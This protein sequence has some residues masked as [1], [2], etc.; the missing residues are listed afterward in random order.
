MPFYEHVFVA[1][2]DVT[3]A[4]VDQIADQIGGVVEEAGGK[5]ALR[6]Y[7]GLRNLAYRIRKNRKGHFI[8][9]RMDAPADAVTEFERQLRLNEDVIRILT[10]RQDELD[11]TPSIIMQNKQS[12]DGRGDRGDRGRRDRDDRDDRPPREDRAPRAEAAAEGDA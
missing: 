1:R 10:V 2:Q 9:L 12:R 7:W 5:I 3:A 11:E 8:M 4:Q 6:E